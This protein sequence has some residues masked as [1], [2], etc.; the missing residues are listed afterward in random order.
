M[1]ALTVA[2][3]VLSF[4]APNPAYN[5]TALLLGI[6]VLHLVGLRLVLRRAPRKIPRDAREELRRMREQLDREKG[7]LDSM[8]RE[9]E[10]QREAAEQQWGLLRNM[11]QER[12]EKAKG[13][14]MP[15]GPGSTGGNPS[16]PITNEAKPAAVSGKSGGQNDR[17]PLRIHSRW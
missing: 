11:V 13:G 8:R 16:S 3:A 4:V 9:L 14:A 12:M 5:L 1:T 7:E 15:A 17:D 10:R 2:A 6:Y